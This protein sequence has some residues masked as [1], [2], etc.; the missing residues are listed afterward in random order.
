MLFSLLGSVLLLFLLI[1]TAKTLMQRETTLSSAQGPEAVRDPHA[2][3]ALSMAIGCRTI[4]HENADATEWEAFTRLQ[5]LLSKTYSLCETMRLTDAE[6]GPHNLVY[7]FEGK[8]A[9]CEPALLT[10]HLDVVGA[11]EHEW[12]HPPFAGHI[13]DGYVWGRGSFDC[14]LQV[15]TILEACEEML[16]RGEQPHRTWYIAFGCD[17]ECNASGEG[18]TR[19]SSWFAEQGLHFS[20]VL[21]EGG[22]V[23][24]NYIKGFKQSIAVV[25]VAEKGYLDLELRVK[26]EA[27]HS[28]TPSF[29][30]ALGT[31]SKGLARLERHQMRPYLT[32]PVRTMLKSLGQQGPF[33]YSLLFLNPGLFKQVLFSLFSKNPTLN[34]LIRTTVVPTV[35]SASDKSNVIALEAKAHVNIRL[36]I[37]Q[38]QEEAI[39][40]V[41][42][43]LADPSIQVSILRHTPPSLVSRTDTEV[44]AG[45][46]STILSTFPEALVTPYLM[47]GATDARKYQ[48]LSDQVFRFTPARMNKREIARMHGPDERIGCENIAL[49]KQFYNRLIS[50]F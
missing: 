49:A 41:K 31:L 34:A 29:P 24:Q 20:L 21:D 7:R 28:S 33:G 11:V 43:T 8:D 12:S 13:A 3:Q 42:R 40:W 2:E 10:A 18:A 15:I 6:L 38:K 46:K 37:G 25:G 1:L 23:S 30:T 19:I 50:T 22:V 16:Q 36:L 44:F 5:Q 9:S 17:E 39:A 45:L 47:L 32:A 14:K 27:G 48:A 4:S 26:R 35:V